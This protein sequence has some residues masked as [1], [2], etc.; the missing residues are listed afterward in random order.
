MDWA[1]NE[2]LHWRNNWQPPKIFHVHGDADNI[3]PINKVAPD[4]VIKAGGHFMIMNKA[5]EVS[6]VL[7]NILAG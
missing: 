1:I 7:R 2:V 4:Y 6:A 5:D 3:F